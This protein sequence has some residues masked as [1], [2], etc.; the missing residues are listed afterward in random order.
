MT[1]PTVKEMGVERCWCKRPLF[2]RLLV[3]LRFEVARDAQG[4]R[5]EGA[6]AGE[7]IF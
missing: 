7:P 2:R 4:K 6:A 1:R 5:V 3:C